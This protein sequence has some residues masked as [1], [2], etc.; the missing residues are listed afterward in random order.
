MHLQRAHSRLQ[1]GRMR[2][3][4]LGH[5]HARTRSWLSHSS[6][7]RT[8]SSNKP[9]A[10]SSSFLSCTMVQWRQPAGRTPRSEARAGRVA[11]NY[12][13]G[14]D[15]PRSVHAGRLSN[16]IAASTNHSL[17]FRRRGPQKAYQYI[18]KLKHLAACY[19]VRA[20]PFAPT[21]LV[22]ARRPPSKRSRRAWL[23]GCCSLA[24]LISC[25]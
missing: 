7:S 20:Q 8:N 25:R 9:S 16:R 14:R 12:E 5:L 11:N 2:Q 6:M 23:G 24:R 3:A 4:E 21:A 19:S 17:A 18:K 13:G 15:E 10:S 1:H 22:A